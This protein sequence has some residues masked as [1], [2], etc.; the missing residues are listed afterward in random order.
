MTQT[1]TCLGPMARPHRPPTGGS[2]MFALATKALAEGGYRIVEFDSAVGGGSQQPGRLEVGR[3]LKTI[4]LLRH[5]ESAT[6]RSN[7][8]YMHF[9]GTQLGILRDSIALI[10]A[11][12]TSPVVVHS[13]NGNLV[14]LINGSGVL[15][16]LARYAIGRRASRLIVLSKALMPPPFV[17]PPER[18][19]V[20]HNCIADEIAAA[21]AQNSDA[22]LPKPLRVLYLANLMP[23]K[24]FLSVLEAAK[25]T[26]RRFG[27]VVEFHFCGKFY[28]GAVGSKGGFEQ[29]IRANALERTVYY[30]GAV[31]GRAKVEALKKCS[32]VILPTLY[33]R[34]GLPVCLIEGLA[35][36]LPALATN[37]RGIPDVLI[38][39]RTGLFIQ[40]E[41]ESIVNAIGYLISHPDK[42]LAMSAECRRLF[43]AEFGVDTF[44]ARLQQVIREVT[45]GYDGRP[46]AFAAPGHDWEH[47]R[48]I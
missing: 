37:F 25:I 19:T 31:G 41:P 35:F 27:R 32:V 20:I 3:T 40:Q 18:C 14:G 33:S 39:G 4:A 48:W 11:A 13:H 45:Q 9:S 15:C 36:G 5:V 12:R 10:R 42:Y 46:G 29:L 23:E 43:G 30:H 38:P 6:R 28:D 47:S 1:I 34:E 24:G 16:R 7:A 17:V 21:G 8:L 26:A 44:A 22:K 2:T